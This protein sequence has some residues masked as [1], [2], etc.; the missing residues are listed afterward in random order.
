MTPVARTFAVT[1]DMPE[2][3]DQ[4]RHEAEAH[5]RRLPYTAQNRAYSRTQ[6]PRVR[7]TS[8]L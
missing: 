5:Q 8:S 6:F 3:L 1:G 2:D 7:K 4:Q